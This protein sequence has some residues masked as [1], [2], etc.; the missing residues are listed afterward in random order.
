MDKVEIVC[1]HCNQIIGV[2]P[3][4]GKNIAICEKTLEGPFTP[5]GR[6]RNWRVNK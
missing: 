3:R 4:C 6:Y 1:Q 5:D 2:C